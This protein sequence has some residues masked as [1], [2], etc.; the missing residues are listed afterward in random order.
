MNIVCT[1][2]QELVNTLVQNGFTEENLGKEIT[3]SLHSHKPFTLM[4]NGKRVTVN[5]AKTK[6]SAYKFIVE[7]K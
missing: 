7:I 6:R 1:G 5:W 3:S 4:E 2:K